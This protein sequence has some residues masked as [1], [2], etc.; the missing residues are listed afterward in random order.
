[1]SGDLS[2]KSKAREG[3]DY[4]QASV[5]KK[6]RKRPDSRLAAAA[7]FTVQ[8]SFVEVGGRRQTICRV[9][10]NSDGKL[11]HVFV[12]HGWVFT[13]QTGGAA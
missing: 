2:F 11:D 7:A 5:V 8:R 6:H 9:L 4:Q 10:R 12:L 13:H 3:Q 1:M